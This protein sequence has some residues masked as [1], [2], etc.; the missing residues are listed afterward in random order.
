MLRQRFL[1]MIPLCLALVACGRQESTEAPPAPGAEAPA[2]PDMHSSRT[3]LDWAGTYEGVLP[4]VDCAGIRTRLTLAND[5]SFAMQTLPL[6]SGAEEASITGSFSWRPDGNA[7]TLEG[8]GDGRAFQVGEGRLMVLNVDGSRPGPEAPGGSLALLSG[9]E[10]GGDAVTP[11]LLVDHRWRLDAATQAGGQRID[12]LFPTERP[13]EFGF[14]AERLVVT[15]GCNGLRGGYRFDDEGRFVAGAMAS[16]LMACDEPLMQADRSLAALLSKPLRPVLVRG[17]E[18]TLALVSADD[19]VLVLVGR[20]TPEALY[21]PATRVFL[22]VAAQTVPCPEPDAGSQCLSVREIRF[23]DQGL[24]AG[25]PG[26]WQA[27][28]GSIEGFTHE[29]GIR[30]IV[31]VNRHQRADGAGQPVHVLDLVVESEIVRD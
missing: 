24:R 1:V 18:P 4:C 21:G 26:E 29:P 28:V 16:T 13:F 6:R 15:G 3:S 31:R 5:G 2:V 14:E 25:E 8:P 9:V 12:A 23:D 30:S 10:A 7:I 17:S 27:F 22:E 20:K 11:Q 19:E